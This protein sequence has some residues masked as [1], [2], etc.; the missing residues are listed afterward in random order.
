M[1]F[2]CSRKLWRLSPLDS[3]EDALSNAKAAGR[4][5]QKKGYS[6]VRHGKRGTACCAPTTDSVEIRGVIVLPESG[7]FWRSLA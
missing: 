3:N 7:G 4:D 1:E 5:E 6:P 2:L